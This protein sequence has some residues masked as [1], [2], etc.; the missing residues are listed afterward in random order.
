MPKITD[1]IITAGAVM[2]KNYMHSS[3][4]FVLLSGLHSPLETLW[5]HLYSKTSLCSLFLI[6]VKIWR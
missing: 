6:P 3:V 5:C 2:H 1:K 4:T